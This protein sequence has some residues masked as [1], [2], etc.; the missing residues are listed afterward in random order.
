MGADDPHS[1]L[2]QAVMRWASGD[3]PGVV[4]RR[5]ERFSD[6]AIIPHD[7]FR[8]SEWEA[9]SEL[10]EAVAEALGA[11]RLARMGEVSGDMRESG[12]EMLLGDDDWVV[13]RESGVDYGYRMTRCMFSSGNVN[14]RRRMGEVT[15]D[16]EVLV[17][18]YAGIGY[19]TLPAL[20]HG[21]ASMVHACEWNPEAIEALKWGLETNGVDQRCVV[22]EG[23][24]R[25]ASKS[26]EGVADRVFLGL[27]PSSEDGLEVALRVLSQDGGTLHIHGLAPSS[28]HSSWA[29]GVEAS[30]SAIRP[31]SHNR[32][33]LV[34]VKSYAPHWDHVV[35]DLSVA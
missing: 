9:D 24:S 33:G 31:G 18:L 15:Q 10:W 25:E 14:E 6:V 26:L 19:Y 1:R 2:E 5:W 20:V 23:D 13:R 34:R 29:E 22:H 4:P 30:A 7:S 21:G 16:D 17:D 27:L 3:L 11:K 8:G 35:L 12:V 32:S 28:D